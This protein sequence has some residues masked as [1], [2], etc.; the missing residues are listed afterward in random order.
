MKN[1]KVLTLKEK[2]LLTK[3][4]LNPDEWLRTKK[5]SQHLEFVHRT[6]DKTFTLRV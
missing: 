4:G 2:K 1:G 5:T 3:E 6:D